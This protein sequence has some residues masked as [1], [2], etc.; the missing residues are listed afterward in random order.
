MADEAA[1]P[2]RQAA[3][4]FEAAEHSERIAGHKRDLAEKQLELAEGLSNFKRTAPIAHEQMQKAAPLM[5]A[6]A[7]KVAPDSRAKLEAVAAKLEQAA[8]SSQKKLEAF[9]GRVEVRHYD[10]L[11]DFETYALRCA[12]ASDPY[13]CPL[14]L[15]HRTMFR[16]PPV[17]SVIPRSKLQH[18][19]RLLLS[20][21]RCDAAARQGRDEGQHGST[22]Q[23]V[24]DAHEIG[25]KWGSRAAP[26]MLLPAWKS[27][28]IIS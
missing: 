4:A 28:K 25:W 6:L 11:V 1:D 27:W 9:W 16:S 8:Q 26:S 2:R 24:F 7:A 18:G 14:V 21:L 5:A 17:L 10:C 12:C 22:Q 20:M 23:N 3:A 13:P 19:R 15:L